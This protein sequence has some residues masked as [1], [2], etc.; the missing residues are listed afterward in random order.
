M[1]RPRSEIAESTRLHWTEVG[2]EADEHDRFDDVV[3][4]AGIYPDCKGQSPRVIYPSGVA[5]GID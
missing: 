3:V 5:I 4:A 2:D 1:S